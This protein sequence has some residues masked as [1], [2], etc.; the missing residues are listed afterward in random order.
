[1]VETPRANFIAFILPRSMLIFT[2][3]MFNMLGNTIPKKEVEKP[4]TNERNK[5]IVI[6]FSWTNNYQLNYST[7]T[8]LMF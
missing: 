5:V 6:F 1:M 7:I 3:V 2:V 8:F 4:K